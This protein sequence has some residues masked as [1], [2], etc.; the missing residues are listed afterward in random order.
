VRLQHFTLLRQ[1]TG[2]RGMLMS[3]AP[4]HIGSVRAPPAVSRGAEKL[5]F[6]TIAFFVWP[7]IAVGVVGSYGFLIWMYQII[8]GPPGPPH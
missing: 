1:K 6:L 7:V 3:E 4:D 8:F 5:V 2:E